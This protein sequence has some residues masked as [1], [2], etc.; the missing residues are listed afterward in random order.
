MTCQ[1]T[2]LETSGVLKAI[3]PVM[4]ATM[5]RASSAP[6]HIKTPKRSTMGQERL[7]AL[8][9]LYIQKGISLNH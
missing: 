8:L 1:K 7:N 9:L 6:K 5:E 4:V 3:T 2:L